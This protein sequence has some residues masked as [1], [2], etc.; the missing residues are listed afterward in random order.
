MKE[1]IEGSNVIFTHGTVDP[2]TSLTKTSD[3]KHWSVVLAEIQGGWHNSDLG[4]ACDLIP[5]NCANNNMAQVQ[6]MT[7]KM[8]ERWIDP[9][10]PV[11]DSVEITD[12]VGKRPQ[13]FDPIVVGHSSVTKGERAYEEMNVKEFSIEQT[14][15][16][17]NINEDRIFNQRFWLNDEFGTPNG[18]NFLMIGSN[19]GESFVDIQ[20]DELPWVMYANTVNANIFLLEHRYYG[21]SKLGTNDL[22]YLS[23]FQMIYDITYFIR[24]QQVKHNKT[25]PWI[26]FGSSYGGS[27]AV[28]SREWF[29]EVISGAVTS[30]SPMLLKNDFYESFH[31]VEQLI[32]NHSQ[33]C[34]DRIADSF[35]QLRKDSMDPEGRIKLQ[36]K[37]NVVPQWEEGE[38]V[39]TLNMNTL[40]LNIYSIFQQVVT[41]NTGND[42][43]IRICEYFE[44]TSEYPNSVDALRR[45]YFYLRD[46]SCLYRSAQENYFGNPI[47]RDRAIPV[48]ISSIVK[49][50]T[51]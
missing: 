13:L 2:W 7:M 46:K 19:N 1:V 31:V 22:Q 25:G 9:V 20:N 18:P 35:Y 40:F 4:T 44:N 3:A 36:E 28:W 27:L 42:I 51:R 16:H 39:S 14:W 43:Q 15:D 41:E 29:P 30:S 48:S 8:I 17:F 26:T 6:A 10:F 23:S 12:N 5:P 45:L 11:P 32:A 50:N 24:T 21:E 33:L 47:Y 49:L 34:F 37:F 38:E